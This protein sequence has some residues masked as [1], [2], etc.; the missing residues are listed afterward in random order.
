VKR[1]GVWALGVVL[2]GCDHGAA[3]SASPS[4]PPSAPPTSS[5]PPLGAGIAAP[6][7]RALVDPPPLPVLRATATGEVTRLRVD[8]TGVVFC[9][10]RGAHA[11][12][13]DDSVKPSAF[14]CPGSE[15]AV[16]SLDE[17]RSG[18]QAAFVKEQLSAREVPPNEVWWVDVGKGGSI[19]LK[20]HMVACD[21][22]GLFFVI[23]TYQRIVAF[24]AA[25]GELHTVAEHGAEHVAIG[26]RWVA[27]QYEQQVEAKRR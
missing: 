22:D 2:G 8:E 6:V 11:L 16:A 15:S 14:R 7:P 5:G 25:R 10:A 21:T 23:S 12:T 1:T 20:G 13:E 18:C 19:P 26:A 24:D 17:A 4:P 3:V 9:D 27:W